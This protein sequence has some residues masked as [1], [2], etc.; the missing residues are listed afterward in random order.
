VYRKYLSDPTEDVRVATEILL[1]D[2]LREIRDVSI[3]RKRN[4]EHAKTKK[5]KEQSEPIRR[6]DADKLPDITLSHP[7]RA[8]FLQEN[9]A[10]LSDSEEE[11]GFRDEIK[12]EVDNR[13]NG[14]ESGQCI[15]VL[16]R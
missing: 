2:F 6:A 1:A 8:A 13:D 12:A 3:V 11:S 10:A 16:L 14:G 15:R 5:D 9:G 4:E 7:E